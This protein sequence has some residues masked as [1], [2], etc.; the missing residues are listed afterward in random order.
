MNENK[1]PYLQFNINQSTSTA[2]DPEDPDFDESN[3]MHSINGYVYGNLP[4][5][6]MK[7]DERVRFYLAS[8]KWIIH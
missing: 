2:V 4:G 7:L 8:I 6:E 3:L 1:S 5:L